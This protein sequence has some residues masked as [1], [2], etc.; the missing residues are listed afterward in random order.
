MAFYEKPFYRDGV[1]MPIQCIT[2]GLDA[3][4]NAPSL[5]YH[6][7]T[8]LLFGLT[9]SAQ[10]YIGA[11]H[12]TLQAGGMV[13][14]HTGCP[15]D[16]LCREG[17]CSYIVVKFLPQVLLADEQTPSAYGHV[18]ALMENSGEKQI[19]FPPVALE[20]TAL[21]ALFLHIRSEWQ[22]QALGYEL[23]LRADVTQIYLYI[24]RRWEAQH[25]PLLSRIRDMGQTEFIKHAIAYVQTHYPDLTAAE[26]ADACGVSATYFSRM[27]KRA[28]H[29]S[30]SD[31]VALVR[32]RRAEQ[33]LLFTDDSITEIAQ[34]VGFSTA[35]YF[36]SRFRETKHMTP[37]QFRRAAK[38][39][40][41]KR[42]APCPRNGI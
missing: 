32:L 18:L 5:H 30:F 13:I 40:A 9:G 8:E 10:V 20:K 2:V 25:V 41:E 12:Y 39:N 4:A 19:A 23:S 3:S 38:S 6:E 33:L 1:R 22:E 21:P 28:M 14:V 7:Y 29:Q 36:I 35:S 15:H 37:L 27:F 31:Y 24:L 42:D 26:T 11:K 16:V 17:S 34:A